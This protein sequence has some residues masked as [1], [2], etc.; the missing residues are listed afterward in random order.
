MCK[1]R[2]L[3][4]NLDDIFALVIDQAFLIMSS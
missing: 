2:H 1:A 3:P 4:G